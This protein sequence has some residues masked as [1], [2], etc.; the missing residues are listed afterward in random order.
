MIKSVNEVNHLQENR[1]IHEREIED[2]KSS[3][4]TTTYYSKIV[5]QNPSKEKDSGVYKCI[6]TSESNNSNERLHNIIVIGRD[7]SVLELYERSG[8]YKTETKS[9]DRI[10]VNWN[11]DVN[12]MPKP[13]TYW[14]NN[15]GVEI[16]PSHGSASNKYNVKTTNTTSTLTIRNPD[17]N[18]SGEYMVVAENGQKKLNRTFTL[19]V[20][21][22][23]RAAMAISRSFIVWIFNSCSDRQLERCVHHGIRAEELDL[24]SDWISNVDYQVVVPAVLR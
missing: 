12:G 4:D 23:Y 15:K 3:L 16:V 18:D 10:N 9:S 5:V 19:V 14:L 6:V 17:W 22:R 13:T 1:L 7:E 11:V 21:C 8:I 20:K 24:R 2:D